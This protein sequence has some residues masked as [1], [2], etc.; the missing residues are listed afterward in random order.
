MPYLVLGIMAV[1][2]SI[3]CLFLPETAMENLPESMEEAE[4]FGQLQG[5]FYVPCLSK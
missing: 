5:F 3:T 2:G 4:S 1:V